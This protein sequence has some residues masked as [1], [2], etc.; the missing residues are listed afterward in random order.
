MTRS[1]TPC[2]TLPAVTDGDERVKLWRSRWVKIS[3]GGLA[4]A[5]LVVV[6]AIFLPRP[7]HGWGQNHR[8][9]FDDEF[10]MDVLIQGVGWLLVVA[11]IGISA[12]FFYRQRSDEYARVRA[13]AEMHIQDRALQRAGRSLPRVEE[14][15]SNAMAQVMRFDTYDVAAMKSQAADMQVL[16]E[17]LASV[18]ALRPTSQL[19]LFLYETCKRVQTYVSL[20]NSATITLLT[21]QVAE[22]KA[23]LPLAEFEAVE[24]ARMKMRKEEMRSFLN[25]VLGTLE[26]WELTG[27]LRSFDVP[28][29]LDAPVESLNDWIL[30][31]ESSA[32]GAI[33]DAPRQA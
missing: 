8:A 21:R 5:A 6:L 16:A 11:S 31:S 10:W 13:E 29:W 23:Q 2:A 18:A 14:A 1:N 20:V 15:I 12:A 4:V 32:Q 27:R 22:A 17:V 26:G 30:S 7:T 19:S 3:L 33:A 25:L 9:W 28:P 24:T